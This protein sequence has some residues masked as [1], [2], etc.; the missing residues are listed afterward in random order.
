MTFSHLKCLLYF[1][2]LFQLACT[3]KMQNI[4]SP[5]VLKAVAIRLCPGQDVRQQLQNLAN[6]QQWEAACIISSVGSLTH[7][8]IRHANQA[9]ASLYN[10]HFEVTSLS[11]TLSKNG[12]HLHLSI[13]D[14]TGHSFGGH[15]MDGCK[16]YT[17]MELVIGI[18]PEVQ[19]LREIDSTYGYK[20]L[21]VKLKPH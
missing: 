8:A 7:A 15:M 13:A 20:E 1:S 3:Q 18:L 4:T 21:V 5:S 9:T 19:F 6:E 14:S 2:F 17:T 16:V 12:S 11:G 10:G